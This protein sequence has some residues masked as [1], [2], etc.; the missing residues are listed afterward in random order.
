MKDALF[1]AGIMFLIFPGLVL[2]RLPLI[3]R[4]DLAARLAIAFAGG[5]AIVTLLL[6][7]YNFAHVPW[8]RTTVGIPLVALSVLGLRRAAAA[9]G[10]SAEGR[11]H[12]ASRVCSARRDRRSSGAT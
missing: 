7:V 11:G 1:V 6:Y 5:V 4:L 3:V 9:A 8:T 10:S 2:W 12:R